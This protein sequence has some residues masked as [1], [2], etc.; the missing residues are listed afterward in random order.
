MGNVG[1]WESGLENVEDLV[2]MEGDAEALSLE[3]NSMDGYTIA[4]GIRNVT[5]IDR[6]LK[7]AHR[8]LRRGGR[9]LC[10]ELSHVSI[11]GFQQVYDAYS[12]AVIP[13]MGE[14]VSGDRASYQY[15]VESI[16]KFPPQVSR[17]R[18]PSNSQ[19]EMHSWSLL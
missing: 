8:V 3:D 1:G 17:L 6:A 16:R 7:E 9:F 4:F 13:A 11:P 12:F 5:H 15:L 14:L 19:E 2:W 18:L 10:L